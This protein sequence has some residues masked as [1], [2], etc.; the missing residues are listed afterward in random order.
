MRRI[1]S[2]ES[3][4]HFTFLIPALLIILFLPIPL[5]AKPCNSPPIQKGIFQT[6]RVFVAG[7]VVHDNEGKSVTG[8]S[9]ADFVALADGKPQRV[10]SFH[11]LGPQQNTCTGIVVDRSGS[12][13]RVFPDAELPPIETFVAS[14]VDSN[15]GAFLVAFSDHA[16]SIGGYS[17]S[18]ADL[19]RELQYL[20]SIAPHGMKAL[21][22]GIELGAREVVNAQGYRIL[23]VVGDEDNH[24]KFASDE[25][26]D[27]VLKARA[28]VYFVQLW[29]DPS[30]MNT[31][32]EWD[33]ASFARK[34]TAETGGELLSVHKE[35]D[36]EKAFTAVREELANTYLV[37]FRP[38]QLRE[39]TEFHNLKISTKQKDLRVIAPTRFYWPVKNEPVT[40]SQGR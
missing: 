17:T 34:I 3:H 23:L 31:Q 8:L 32:R 14:D 20:G 2:A 36:L 11:N 5:L 27:S 4:T 16:F 38:S 22:D 6:V 7:V 29:P 28:A 12:R 25:V 18:A 9:A 30:N 24:S 37:G 1:S 35:A 26:I 33:F 15:H 19:D 10:I 39:K 13:Q 40:A 21:N